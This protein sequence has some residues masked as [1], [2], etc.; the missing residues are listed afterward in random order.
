MCLEYVEVARRGEER[1]EGKCLVSKPVTGRAGAMGTQGVTPP[2]LNFA[3]NP[4]LAVSVFF[5]PAVI[6]FK[7]FLTWLLRTQFAL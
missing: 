3:R 1:R 7:T 5:L 2:L 6:L 4:T